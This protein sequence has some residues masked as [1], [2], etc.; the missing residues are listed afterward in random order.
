VFVPWRYEPVAAGFSDVAGGLTWRALPRWLWIGTEHVDRPTVVAWIPGRTG[1]TIQ[2]IETG[3]PVRIKLPAPRTADGLVT[4]GGRLV[5]GR[6]A[7][8]RVVAAYHGRGMFDKFLSLEMTAQAGGQFH[9]GGLTPGKFSIQAARDGIW[10]SR[11]V[12]LT[13]ADDRDPPAIALDIPEPGRPIE[14]HVVDREGRPA[15]GRPIG[16]VR[17][18]GPL[19]SLWPATLHTGPGGILT[20]RGLEAGRHSLLIGEAKEP[21]EIAVP[22]AGAAAA[23]AIVARIVVPK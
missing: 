1:A 17:P 13:I 20:L 6:N 5:A 12:E 15:A 14:L 16:L 19:A 11:S 18:D 21:H 23:A 9:L 3:K 8:I 4:L 2:Q 7:R 22:A 10:L